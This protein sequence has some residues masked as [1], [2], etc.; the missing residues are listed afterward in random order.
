LGIVCET[1]AK[2]GIIG[3]LAK[4]AG[5]VI[6]LRADMDALPI[7]EETG[8][9]FSSKERRIMHACGHDIH[10]T[11]LIGAAHLL[12]NTEFAGTVKFVFQPSEEGFAESPEPGKSGGQLVMES[13][14]LSGANAAFG[15]HVHPLMPVGMIGFKNGVA[16]AAKTSFK[17][18]LTAAGGHMANKKDNA[19][20]L[21]VAAEIINSANKYMAANFKKQ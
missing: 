16:L 4:G 18:V 21:S 12:S 8:L 10:T 2:T 13:G 6:V 1:V 19:D 20:V 14:K 7:N 9:A 3:T 5:A 11:M 17:I 15:L